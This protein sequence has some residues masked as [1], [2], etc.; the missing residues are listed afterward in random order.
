MKKK[1][2]KNTLIGITSFFLIILGFY[3][4]IIRVGQGEFFKYDNG[5]TIVVNNLSEQE[6]TDLNFF[7]SF[8]TYDVHQEYRQIRT[9]RNH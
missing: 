2:F 3:Y 1:S 6:V 5:V 7:F 4:L 9:G 8:S